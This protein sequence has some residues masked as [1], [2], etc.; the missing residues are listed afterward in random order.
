LGSADQFPN[1]PLIGR[2]NSLQAVDF[3]EGSIRGEDGVYPTV[4][5]KGGEDGILGIEA[6]VSL[7]EVDSPVNVIGLD[8]MPP[9]ELCNASRSFRRAL[10]V[11]G[12]PRSL[13]RE[14]LKQIDTGL[15]L[16]ITHGGQACY[17]AARVSIRVLSA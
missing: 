15:A 1:S 3:V 8:R 16:Q 2:I 11:A 10:S 14:L 17:L 9:G 4:D 6:L 12:S 5:R 7:E 13:V